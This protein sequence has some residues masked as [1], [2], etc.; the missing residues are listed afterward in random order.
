MIEGLYARLRALAK[1]GQ[2]KQALCLMRCNDLPSMK[3]AFR[4][5][6]S[7]GG[8]CEMV[9]RFADMEA[10]HAADR[11]WHGFRKATKGPSSE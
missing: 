6:R 8:R 7:I 9:F 4:I 11:E 1:S 10:M 3:G 5:T 2:W